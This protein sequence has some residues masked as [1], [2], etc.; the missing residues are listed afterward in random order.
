MTTV[1]KW[2]REDEAF[3]KQ[4]AR[5]REDQAD[6]LADDIVE[7]ADEAETKV[8]IG[9][10]ETHVVVFD[11]TA[12]ARNKLRVDARKWVAAKLRPKKYGDKVD[13]NHGG[14]V[15]FALNVRRRKDEPQA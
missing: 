15:G 13:L 14:S 7:I 5:A 1:F 9:S 11:S 8:I 12:V 3:A 6:A 4:Y 2:L 10:D